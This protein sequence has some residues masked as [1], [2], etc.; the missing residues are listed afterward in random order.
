MEVSGTVSY[1]G[2]AVI[3]TVTD[4]LLVSEPDP[5]GSEYGFAVEGAVVDT[6]QIVKAKP[7]FQNEFSFVNGIP[8]NYTD[9]AENFGSLVEIQNLIEALS[10]HIR[11]C[12]KRG[13]GKLAGL[14]VKADGAALYHVGT[15]L[16]SNGQVF[17]VG[18][19]FYKVICIKKVKVI[20]MGFFDS[21]ISTGSCKPGLFVEEK[22][23][24]GVFLLVIFYEG[25]RSV[26]G[27]VIHT[28]HLQLLWISQILLQY[29][30]Q[31]GCDVFLSIVNR[32][33]SG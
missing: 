26:G 27:C 15:R 21:L 2:C 25:N 31:S 13:I 6:D 17:L 4:N 7:L 22:A 10:G 5:V 14:I 24:A 3:H 8:W 9:V 16:F 28:D 33:D 32:D 1:K 18:T 11:Q 30:V 20:T 23:D 19:F 12:K 29:T